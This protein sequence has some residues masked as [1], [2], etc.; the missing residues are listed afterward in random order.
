MIQTKRIATTVSVAVAF[1]LASFLIDTGDLVP[2]A[3]KAQVARVAVAQTF[4][5]SPGALFDSAYTK[6]RDGYVDR[7][8][9]GQ[10][11]SRW[12]DR[13]NGKLKTMEDSHK[14]IQTMLAS[15]GDPYTRF[16]SKEAFDEEKNQISAKLYG[17]G[18]QLGMSKEHKVVVIAP[19][20]DT[21]AYRAGVSPGDEVSEIDGK[22]I[23]GQALDEVV[24]QI[25]G[26]LGT[27]VS[28]TLLRQAKPVTINLVRAEVPIKAVANATMLPDNIGYIRLD[29]FISQKATDEMNTA[30]SQLSKADG[31]II[32]LR[33][34]PGG[35]LANAIDI[36]NQFLPSGVIVSTIDADGQK[37]SQVASGRQTVHQPLVI[38]VNGGSASASEIFSAA[39]R[40][41]G[42]AKIVGQTTFGKGLVQAIQKLEDGSG[43]NITIAKYVTPT[44]EDIHKKGIKPDFEVALSDD[45]YKAGK[46]PWWVDVNLSSFKHA[47]TD[48]KDI[49]LNKAIEVL[50]GKTV[51]TASNNSNTTIAGSTTIA[52]PAVPDPPPKS[53]KEPA[54]S[55]SSSSEPQSSSSTS[56]I[57]RPVRDKWALV[58]GISKFANPSYNL[59]YASKDARDFYNFLVN[60]ANFKKDHVLMLLDERATRSS[61]MSAFGDNYLPAV[62]Q[63]GDLVVVYVS[64]HGTPAKVDKGGRNYIVAHDTDVNALYATG[65]DM[66]ELYRRIRE[67]VKTDRALIVMDTC[68][69]GAGIPGSKALGGAANFDAAEIAQ[70]CGRLVITS[71]SPNEKS[72]ESRVTP[73]GIFTKYLLQAL[74]ANN[75]KADVRGAFSTLQQN[76]QWE[77]QNAFREKQTPQLGGN[78]EGRDLILSVPAT[79]PRQVFNPDLLKMMQ[80]SCE[81]P[82]KTLEPATKAKPPTPA[83][84]KK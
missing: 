42:R 16:L 26:P 77:V 58:I 15:L 37:A 60:E 68:F 19:I 71:S 14:A 46:G 49:Q 55:A 76:V 8:F 38:L 79:A 20:E 67:G 21:P 83:P 45:D 80:E 61:I 23:K 47:P 84:R 3:E 43:M 72:W 59:K 78:W 24:K 36:S 74:R 27:K 2:F 53:T 56:A 54:T 30:L 57:N 17:V 11:W 41:N 33:N 10:D 31:L 50:T 4:N 34:N 75:K 81:A 12:K 64:T 62:T 69:S 5:I 52:P 65:V 48:G 35:L 66:D 44:D 28:L 82:P 73:N 1:C 9:N 51:E 13:Y 6:I 18:M 25:R 40:D 22:S 29:S 39:M 7:T 63:D 32:D 70:G